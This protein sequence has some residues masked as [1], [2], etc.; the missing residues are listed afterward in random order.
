MPVPLKR[1]IELFRECVKS[2]RDTQFKINDKLYSLNTRTCKLRIDRCKTSAGRCWSNGT[3][4]ISKYYIESPVVNEDMM[5]DT[6]LHELAHSIAG[7]DNG[8]NHIWY[9]ICK[10]IGCSGDMYCKRFAK[11]K[12]KVQC[13]KGC[14]YG[15]YNRKALRKGQKHV[16][17]RNHPGTPVLVQHKKQLI[18]TWSDIEEFKNMIS[19]LSNEFLKTI[20]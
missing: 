18:Q 19:S 11:Y 20:K 2:V 15:W 14:T 1:T 9:R 3:I 10:A 6:I 5:R 13:F 7:L 8:H 12:Y 4:T 16:C 17:C